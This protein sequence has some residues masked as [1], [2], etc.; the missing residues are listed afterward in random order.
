M[1]DHSIE[2]LS[3]LMDG[4]VEDFELR[5]TLERIES[6]PELAATWERFHVARSVLRNEDIGQ[7]NLDI[8]SAVMS[9]LDAEPEYH[10]PE[11]EPVAA[12]HRPSE[13]AAPFWKPLT[14][15]AVAASVTAIVILGVQNNQVAAPE[16]ADNRPS[17]TLPSVQSS[18]DFVQ[19]R[20]GNRLELSNAGPEPEIIRLSQGIERYIDQHEHMLTSEASSWN[21]TW[22]P[23]GFDELRLD[24]MAHAEVQVFSNGRNSFSVCIEDLGHQSVPEGVATSGKMVAVGKRMGE[25]FVTVVGDVPLMIA[26]RIATSVRAK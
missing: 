4:E 15:M 13:K 6:D 1:A 25:H 10:V 11:S 24:V 19:A 2:S 16:I 23:E 21:A 18:S 26:E 5:R 7:D 22:L 9:A 12:S 8:S 14:S 17:Y 20:F 3:A